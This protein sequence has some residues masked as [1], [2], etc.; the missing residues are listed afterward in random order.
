MAFPGSAPATCA[1]SIHIFDGSRKP[2][3]ANLE[4]LYT[5]TDGNQNQVFRDFVKGPDCRI[6]GLR[7]F[8]NFGDRYTVL[9]WANGYFQAGFTPIIVAPNL[10]P[11]VDLMLLGR[12]ATFNFSGA[13]WK[14]IQQKR[15]RLA[16][17]LAAGAAS[18]EDAEERYMN[19]ME[20]RGSVLAA[21][22]NITTA[23]EQIHLPAGTPLDY[24]QQ[25]IWDETMAPD[26][27]FGFADVELVNQTRR[28]AAQG[29]FAPEAASFL[30]HPGATSSYKQVQFGEANLQLTFHENVRETIGGVACVKVEPDIDYYKDLG[31]HAI[32]E[33]IP[34]KLTGGLTDPR[35][36]YVLRWIAGRRAGIPEFDPLYTIV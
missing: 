10:A 16:R 1:L 24:F 25:L 35:Q 8:N 19:L 17:V 36:V 31:A 12:D 21:L 20:D 23:M 13:T 4:V 6:T 32:L 22:L 14:D 9:A 5:V 26:R 15:P 7:Y 18:P 29:L 33:V 2:A 3:P 28:A 30:F 11:E 34:N 27:F